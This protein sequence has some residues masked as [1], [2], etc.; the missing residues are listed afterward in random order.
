MYTASKERII[1][2]EF[3]FVHAQLL[4]GGKSINQYALYSLIFNLPY[5]VVN[6]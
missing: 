2:R 3:F 5:S 6:G 4:S 1:I